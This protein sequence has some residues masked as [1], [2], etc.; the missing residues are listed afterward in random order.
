[1]FSER[2]DDGNKGGDR[3]ENQEGTSH[4]QEEGRAD[5]ERPGRHGGEFL[6]TAHPAKQ[7]YRPVCWLYPPCVIVLIRGGGGGSADGSDRVPDQAEEGPGARRPRQD[8]VWG[9]PQKLLR[10]GSRA[11]QDDSGRSVNPKCSH[12]HVLRV[13]FSTTFFK[14]FSNETLSLTSLFAPLQ[15]WLH[16]GWSWKA[17]QLK[18]RAVPSPSRPGCSA[19]CPWRSSVQWRSESVAVTVGRW[20]S[21]M[22]LY[23][24]I[25]SN[26]ETDLKCNKWEVS[27]KKMK[28]NDYNDDK[29]EKPLSHAKVRWTGLLWGI[30][31]PFLF[32]KWLNIRTFSPGHKRWSIS[33]HFLPLNQYQRI[34]K[35]W[36][37]T[38]QCFPKIFQCPH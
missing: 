32:I 8:P 28:L 36:S 17:S 15:T 3:R 30:N 35:L 25:L 34:T 31:K 10:G 11:R 20:T 5:G 13:Y 26:L 38:I 4:S 6:Q 1:M 19:A 9:I 29:A 2:S 24:I 18:G 33:P 12:S 27:N 22:L 37:P 7:P 21:K 23:Q 14:L 16:S